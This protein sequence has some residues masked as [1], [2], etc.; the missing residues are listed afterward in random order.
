[1]QDVIPVLIREHLTQGLQSFLIEAGK[2]IS[3][4]QLMLDDSLPSLDIGLLMLDQQPT[5]N[6]Q[7]QQPHSHIAT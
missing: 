6:N 4:F 5:T 1:M 7:Q 2:W 3:Q